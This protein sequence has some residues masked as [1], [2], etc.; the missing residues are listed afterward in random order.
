LSPVTKIYDIIQNWFGNFSTAISLGWKNIWRSGA[1][2]FL[3]L[4]SSLILSSALGAISVGDGDVYTEISKNIKNPVI[5]L[6]TSGAIFATALSAIL[7]VIMKHGTL[8]DHNSKSQTVFGL[9]IIVLF[10]LVLVLIADVANKPEVSQDTLARTLTFT[11]C[12]LTITVIKI[13]S[14]RNNSKESGTTS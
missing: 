8:T 1:W 4:V 3:V 14:F 13:F 7:D 5:G 10:L 2:V 11:L 9:A 12:L 6:L